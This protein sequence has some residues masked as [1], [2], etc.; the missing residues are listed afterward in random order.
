MSE[1]TQEE[2]EAASVTV[3]SLFEKQG[4]IYV[5]KDSLKTAALKNSLNGAFAERDEFK[6]KL[7]AREQAE[8]EL[9]ANAK[10]EAYQE[11][12][13]KNDTEQATKLLQEK[14]DD[15]ERRAGESKAKYIE[16]LSDIAK[17]K[18][19][20]IISEI[21]LLGTERG[22]LALSRLLKDY[23]NIDPET[24]NETYL[25]DDGSASSLNKAQFIESLKD[26]D[27][28][29]PL[30]KADITTTGGGNSRG[31]MDSSAIQKDPKQ[32]T[33]E[34]RIEFKKRDPSGFKKAF[35]LN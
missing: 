14:L 29:K 18:E 28:F 1:I 26:N 2:Y 13:A 3:Q 9:I 24:G 8:A 27:L 4:D 32:M 16:R 22:K 15:A 19:R 7:T 33:G 31:S 23:I 21:S 11:A 35:N 12:L 20:V 5:T 34:E 6:G 17:D 10:E 30:L 25:N